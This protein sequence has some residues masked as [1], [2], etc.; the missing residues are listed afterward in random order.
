MAAVMRL[1]SRGY[2]V[3]F[4]RP[5]EDAVDFAH[6]M[7]IT[8]R[9]LHRRIAEYLRRKPEAKRSFEGGPNGN[10]SRLL[11][12]EE[13]DSFCQPRRRKSGQQSSESGHKSDK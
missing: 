6:R 5:W 13:F 10:I 9:T 2:S 1:S 11:S 8:R 4:S 7:G 12:C 3:D